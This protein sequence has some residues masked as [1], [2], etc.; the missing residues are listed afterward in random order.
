[1]SAGPE[2]GA[3]WKSEHGGGFYR[4]GDGGKE[5]FTVLYELRKCKRKEP[6]SWLRDS[7]EPEVKGVDA[8]VI[9]TSKIS[10]ELLTMRYRLEGVVPPWEALDD[11]G[12]ELE[13]DEDD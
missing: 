7:P 11:D 12:E 3:S 8:Y 9:S 10:A 13:D 4:S 6:K 1:M 2:I 5:P